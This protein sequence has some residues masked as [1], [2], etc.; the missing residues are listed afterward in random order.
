[1]APRKETTGF[2]VTQWSPGIKPTW[3]VAEVRSALR[4]HADGDFSASALLVDSMGEDDAIPGFLDKRIDAVLS[5]GFELVPV[6]EPNRQLSVRV[7]KKYQPIWWDIFPETALGSLMRWRRMLGVAIGVLDWEGSGSEW[8]AQLRVLHPQFLRYQ[9]WNQKWIYSAEEGQLEVT[10]GDGR[11]V[12]LTDGDRGWMR[13]AVRYLAI[14][15]LAKQQTIRDWNRYNERHGLPLLLAKAP[16]VAEDPEREQFWD[17]LQTLGNETVVQLATHLDKEGAAFDL[18]LLEATSRSYDSFRLF[19]ERCDHRFLVS[20]LGSNLSTE[21]NGQGS[22]AAADVHQDAEDSR[23]SAEAE[24]L[25]T[26]LRRQCLFPIAGANIAGVTIETTPWPT[27]HT[28]SQPNPIAEAQ[29]QTAFL[30]VISAASSA[31]YEVENIDE[32]A[33]K[34]GLKLK[35]KEPPA[36]PPAPAPPGPPSPDDKGDDEAAAAAE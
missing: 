30:G 18:D 6:D 17:D 24:E 3:T 22:R 4:Q 31:G 25:S 20:L 15:W 23:A 5:K 32:L 35:K 2:R 1:M 28:E 14:D 19:L 12:L 21:V 8:G 34:H 13:G 7:A 9:Q 36:P 10:P 16:L 29:H 26:E 11:W 33:E 27:W